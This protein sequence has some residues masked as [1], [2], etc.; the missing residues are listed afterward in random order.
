M[1]KCLDVHPITYFNAEGSYNNYFVFAFV[2]K[3]VLDA[4]K[5]YDWT[6]IKDKGISINYSRKYEDKKSSI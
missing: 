4:K 6:R 5:A 3:Y 2:I 1:D